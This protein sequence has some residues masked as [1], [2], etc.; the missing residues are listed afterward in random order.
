MLFGFTHWGWK[1]VTRFQ[2]MIF[3]EREEVKQEKGD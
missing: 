2:G 1:Q 3:I